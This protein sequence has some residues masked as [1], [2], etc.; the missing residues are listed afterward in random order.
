MTD[1]ISSYVETLEKVLSHRAVW[2]TLSECAQQKSLPPKND[3]VK[4]RR[5]LSKANVCFRQ[6]QQSPE[7]YDLNDIYLDQNVFIRFRSVYNPTDSNRVK[8]ILEEKYPAGVQRNELIYPNIGDDLTQF[9]K[10]QIVVKLA[11]KKDHP[12][13][14][15]RREYPYH[16]E[17]GPFLPHLDEKHFERKTLLEIQTQFCSETVIPNMPQKEEAGRGLMLSFSDS[18]SDSHGLED[19]F[20]IHF[21][22]I[23]HTLFENENSEQYLKDHYSKM[24]NLK[25]IQPK[26]HY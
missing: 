12:T 7:T 25:K 6:N 11:G 24:Y 2:M 21:E 15:R 22:K 19:V 10:D 3:R 20:D 8:A 17:S 18:Q 1:E 16:M 4:W 5:I 26:K 23:D 14:F 9:Q 13:I